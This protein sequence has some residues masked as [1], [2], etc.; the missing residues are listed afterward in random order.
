MERLDNYEELPDGMKRY[1]K[2][3]GWHFSK[4][5]CEEAVS[6]MRDR[7][8]KKIEAYDKEKVDALL[9]Q[10]GIELKKDAAYDSVYVCN[11]SIADYFGSSISNQ[12]YLAMF[13]RDYIDDEDGY[14]GLPFTRYY[15]DCIGSGTPLIW[16]EML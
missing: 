1:L 14:E 7:N 13:I 10:Y 3:Y 9:K 2:N 4:K 6:R 5:M 11:M 15:A 8:G 12:Q 16:E